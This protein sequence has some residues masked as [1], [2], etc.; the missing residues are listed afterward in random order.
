MAPAAIL[1]VMLAMTAIQTAMSMKAASDQQKSAEAAARRQQDELKR[2]QRRADLVAQ[3]QKSD[4]AREA[5][6]EIGA[7]MAAAA[8]NGSSGAAIAR[9]VGDVGGIEGL[10]VARIESNRAEGQAARHA[11]GI[12][13]NANIRARRTQ[14]KY[15]QFGRIVSGVKSAASSVASYSS[16]YYGALTSAPASGGGG[17]SIGGGGHAMKMM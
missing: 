3:E 1:V 9:M 2:Q 10:D 7:I 12:S 16:G 5:D 11:E 17:G 8:D 15:E 6:R 13:I 14:Y 4:K